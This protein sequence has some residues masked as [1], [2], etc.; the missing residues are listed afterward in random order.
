MVK[1]NC[2]SLYVH[3][4]LRVFF[5]FSEKYINPSSDSDDK[6]FCEIYTK[7]STCQSSELYEVRIMQFQQ[8]STY[9]AIFRPEIFGKFN[10]RSTVI[11]ILVSRTKLLSVHDSSDDIPIQILNIVNILRK[12]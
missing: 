10:T 12:G 2:L 5:S 7:K 4:P 6:N 3:M 8:S 11:Q 9:L 1:L